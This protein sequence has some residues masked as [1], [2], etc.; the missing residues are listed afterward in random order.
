MIILFV[1]GLATLV[2]F[3]KQWIKHGARIAFRRTLRFIIATG[4]IGIISIIITL[5]PMIK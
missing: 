4:V 2:Y 1:F 3:L 5:I